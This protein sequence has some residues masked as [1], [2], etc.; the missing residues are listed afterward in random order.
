MNLDNGLTL[1]P[2]NKDVL[3]TTVLDILRTYNAQMWLPGP[4]K[5]S[6]NYGDSKGLAPLT[7]VNGIVGYVG[8][9]SSEE[10]EENYC[11]NSEFVGATIG[12]TAPSGASYSS[13]Y[14]ITLSCVGVGSDDL[15]NYLDLRFVGT[16]S[17][18]AFPGFTFGGPTLANDLIPNEIASVGMW[19]QLISGTWLSGQ[20]LLMN[21]FTSGLAYVEQDYTAPPTTTRQYLIA[22]KIFTN[23]TVAK[24]NAT[25]QCSAL[26]GQ[27]LDVVVRVWQPQVNKGR[28]RPYR[29]TYGTHARRTHAYIPLHSATTAN[30][31]TFA[32]RWLSYARSSLRADNTLANNW[33]SVNASIDSV[34][35]VP[36]I[37]RC[38]T[39]RPTAALGQHNHR[40]TAVS[41]M[42]ASVTAIGIIHVKT[43]S[44]NPVLAI[45][46]KN[47]AGAFLGPVRFDTSSGVVRATGGSMTFISASKVEGGYWRITFSFNTDTGA[48]V[49]QL[50]VHMYD[51]TS[52]E[53]VPSETMSIGGAYLGVDA[54]PPVTIPNVPDQ[55]TPAYGQDVP[56]SWKFDGTADRLQIA[57]VNVNPAADHFM[58]CCFKMPPVTISAARAVAGYGNSGVQERLQ[59]IFLS[60][61]VINC[62]WRD[63]AGVAVSILSG[64][65]A[66]AVNEKLCITMRKKTGQLYGSVKG[67]ITAP[68][69]GTAA[70]TTAA[71]TPTLGYV[72]GS[73]STGAFVFQWEDE[74]YG[75]ITGSGAP[76]DAE[77]LVM[78]NFLIGCAGFTPV[79]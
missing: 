57:K 11:Y 63:A 12:P 32:S 40:C 1:P 76:T 10:E 50:I 56:Y 58:I 49:P 7:A 46:I 18:N 14:G 47:N 15:G 35:E 70:D 2:I 64:Q 73:V 27:S 53:G 30:K 33:F 51:S 28:L 26:T 75:V 77:L 45:Q 65:P 5:V 44:V 17:A 36:G 61:N 23:A 31:P 25:L 3:E 78:E 72:G 20:S 68:A 66:R 29:P 52:V 48:T 34:E 24:F 39:I 54:T 16:A 42:P 22:S 43:T 62:F 74:I 37:G 21:G 38:V 69:S 79:P 9:Q 8:D 6:E 55:T 67:S 41:V 13:S 19:V 71:W 4:S 59:L 60:N